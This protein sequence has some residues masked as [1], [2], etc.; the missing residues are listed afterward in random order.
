MFTAVK[1]QKLLYFLPQN[2][3]I[4]SKHPF[5]ADFHLITSLT[6]LTSKKTSLTPNKK[7]FAGVIS[8]TGNFSNFVLGHHSD[9][10]L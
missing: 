9:C 4:A 3:D 7:N 10:C 6:S 5:D 8:N 1:I 2:M